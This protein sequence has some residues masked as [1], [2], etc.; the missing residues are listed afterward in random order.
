MGVMQQ[1]LLFSEHEIDKHEQIKDKMAKIGG[2]F[3]G[4]T[5]FLCSYVSQFIS[6]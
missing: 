2:F 3:N 4:F 5:Y 6:R 1:V